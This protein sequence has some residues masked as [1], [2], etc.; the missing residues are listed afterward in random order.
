MSTHSLPDTHG[1]PSCTLTNGIWKPGQAGWG[2]SLAWQE[3]PGSQD[4]LLRETPSKTGRRESGQVTSPHGPGPREVR[5]R[6]IKTPAAPQHLNT[7][8]AF[9]RRLWTRLTLWSSSHTFPS[10]PGPQNPTF[11]LHHP[12]PRTDASVSGWPSRAHGLHLTSSLPSGRRVPDSMG[13]WAEARAKASFQTGQREAGLTGLRARPRTQGER[14]TAERLWNPALGVKRLSHPGCRPPVEGVWAGAGQVPRGS[15]HNLLPP[16][17]LLKRPGG[18]EASHS[19]PSATPTRSQWAGEPSYLRGQ[20]IPKGNPQ[21]L[22][23]NGG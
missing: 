6:S 20:S 21:W 23:E 2:S 10:Q 17:P 16:F 7:G 14:E 3:S 5:Y 12:L 4:P 1:A 15:L 18:T 9:P 8:H 22:E 11:P 13:C 19:S